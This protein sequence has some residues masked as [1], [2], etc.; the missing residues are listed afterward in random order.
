ME[1]I[2]VILILYAGLTHALE[3][4]HVLAVSNIVSGR[5]NMKDAVKD[6]IWW[7]FGHTAVIL[8]I[9]FLMM[10]FKLA[11]SERTFSYFEAAVGLMLVLVAV[12]RLYRFYV[13][14]N[15]DLH[16]HEHIHFGEN[17]TTHLHLPIAEHK[18]MSHG[19]SYGIGMVHGLA[20]SGTLVVLAMSQ[21][22]SASTALFY[23]LLYGLGSVAGMAIVAGLFSIPFSRN[24]MNK[25]HIRTGLVLVSSVIC[26][27]YGFYVMYENIF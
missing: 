21:Y 13:D 15:D 25:N 2:P 19:A 6:G 24:I 23:L 9:G 27:V 12:Y 5:N 20:G 26:L 14:E 3:A 8:L 11:I 7:G 1:N 18:K 4:D 22:E 17:R 10:L 16:R